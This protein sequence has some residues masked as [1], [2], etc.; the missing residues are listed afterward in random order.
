MACDNF[1]NVIVILN[2]S[3][4]IELGFLNEYNIS[5]CIWVGAVGQMGAYAIADVLNGKITPSGKLPDTYAY[6]LLG[7]P[8]MANFGDYTISNSQVDRGNK[9]MVYS[10]GIYVGYRYYETRYEDVVLGNENKNE[11]DYSKQVQ[12]PFGYGL[13]YTTFEWSNYNVVENS[14]VYEVSLKV[15]NNGDFSEKKL[16]KSI[17]N[18]LIQNMTKIMT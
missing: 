4:P 8:S 7:A 10:E 13:S 15:T 5:A 1:K 16:Y 3:N 18:L 9:Y 14:D 6:D 11:Y 12:F 2:S 17:C